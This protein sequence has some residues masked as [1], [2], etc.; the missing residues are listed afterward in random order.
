M[1]Q[2]HPVKTKT[3][4]HPDTWETI[5]VLDTEYYY[6][7]LS[8]DEKLG[9]CH[10]IAKEFSLDPYHIEENWGEA[11]IYMTYSWITKI[12]ELEKKEREKEKNRNIGKGGRSR[13]GR[14]I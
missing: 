6:E 12:Q 7:A 2:K 13:Y 5:N 14:R 11:E 4:R 8:S 10:I 1:F 9:Y 3:S